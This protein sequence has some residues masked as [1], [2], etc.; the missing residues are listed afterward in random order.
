ML[1]LALAIAVFLCA[2][3]ATAQTTGKDL[4]AAACHG[5]ERQLRELAEITSGILDGWGKE[6]S[7]ESARLIEEAEA[8]EQIARRMYTQFSCAERPPL[9]AR[10]LY[11]YVLAAE[12]KTAAGSLSRYLE[13]HTRKRVR[14]A[15]YDQL[16]AIMT[17]QASAD[18]LEV[19]KLSPTVGRYCEELAPL[20]QSNDVP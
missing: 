9:E 11:L 17:R 16:C 6:N 14:S 1:R 4:E 7:K 20:V 18:G 15:D 5:I 13:K 8:R 10:E 2:S 3:L 12:S 19:K